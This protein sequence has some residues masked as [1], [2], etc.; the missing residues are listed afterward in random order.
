[1]ANCTLKRYE[2]K[3][4]VLTSSYLLNVLRGVQKNIELEIT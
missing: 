4:I 1:M 3:N 2:R